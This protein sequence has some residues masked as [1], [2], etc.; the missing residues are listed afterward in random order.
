MKDRR[1]M[2]YTVRVDRLSEQ[3]IPELLESLERRELQVMIT[4]GKS[5]LRLGS[6]PGQKLGRGQGP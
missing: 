6:E 5:S 2:D 1:K 4:F 3:V